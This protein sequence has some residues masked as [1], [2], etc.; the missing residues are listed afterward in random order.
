MSDDKWK[1]DLD[2]FF[3]A[4]EQEDKRKEQEAIANLNN[5]SKE[6][7][8]AATFFHTV[9]KAAFEEIA[10][11]LKQHG[12]MVWVNVTNNSAHIRVEYG[13]VH[14][15]NFTLRA[16]GRIVYTIER[17]NQ[18][19]KAQSREGFIDRA[20]NDTFSNLTQDKIIRHTLERYKDNVRRSR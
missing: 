6:A 18:D 20:F 13:D 16:R 12:R 7:A 14:E 4:Q 8:E 17:F 11:Q 1:Q 5:E 19:G 2:A 9:A 10:T 15:L 3:E